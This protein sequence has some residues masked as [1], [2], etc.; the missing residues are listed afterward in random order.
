MDKKNLNEKIKKETFERKKASS[1]FGHLLKTIRSELKERFPTESDS[2]I[3]EKIVCD[4]YDGFGNCEKD[5]YSCDA[6]K[7]GEYISR[8]GL[9]CRGFQ[10]SLDGQKRTYGEIR[11]EDNFRN[12]KREVLVRLRA[13]SESANKAAKD[14]EE[15]LENEW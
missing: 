15:E 2:I 14:L 11:Q 4:E 13:E 12:A 10:Y 6:C 7:D 5:G 8:F 9:R 3:K 1:N